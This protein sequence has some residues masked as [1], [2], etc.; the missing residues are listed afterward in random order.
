MADLAASVGALAR[1][2]REGDFTLRPRVVEPAAP[3]WDIDA[4]AEGVFIDADEALD[5]TGTYSGIVV[6]GQTAAGVP[7]EGSARDTDPTSPT[8][9]LGPFGLVELVYDSASVQTQ[10]AADALAAQLLAEH[11]GLA[12]S[13]TIETVPNPAL[14]LGDTV[15]LAFPDG[16]EEDHL[17]GVLALPLDATAQSSLGTRSTF[18]PGAASLAS[19]S[20][21]THSALA[22]MA[23][24]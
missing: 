2:D 6:R 22:A 16:R 20:A 24:A 21:R 11:L 8:Y 1:F 13:L 15:R 18:M 3:V 14:E 5:R 23:A 12:R 10:A 9:H 7:I 17:I 4:G 19:R